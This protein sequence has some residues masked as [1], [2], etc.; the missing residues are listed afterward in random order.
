MAVLFRRPRHTL[1]SSFAA[2]HRPILCVLIAPH[3]TAH[4]AQ[5]SKRTDRRQCRKSIASLQP[6][7]RL[8]LP[9]RNLRVAIATNLTGQPEQFGGRS[10]A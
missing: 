1:A 2:W 5:R 3:G 4:A 6:A 8:P 7:C 9:H 10:G